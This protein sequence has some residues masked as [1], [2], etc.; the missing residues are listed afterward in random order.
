MS[1]LSVSMQDRMSFYNSSDLKIGLFGAKCSSGRAI[2]AAPDRWSGSWDDNLHMARI[3]DDAG[4]DF[5]LPI[6]RWRGYKGPTNYE[7]A[8]LETIN[9][10]TGLLAKTRRISV[11]ATMHVPLFHPIVA[12]KSMATADHTG[13]GRF[14]LNL[15][16][17][18]NTDEFA[19]LGVSMREHDTRYTYAQ[20]WLD[21]MTSIWSR[22]DEFDFD[23][24]FF[25]LKN[26]CGLP[27]PYGGS[28]PVVM[29]AGSSGVGTEFALRNCDAF[30]KGV[31]RMNFDGVTKGLRDFRVQAKA[32]GRTVDTYIIGVVCCR[33]T[34]A[35]AEEYIHH[36][37]VEQA[38]WETIDHMATMSNP[39]FP[40]FS[41]A[42]KQEI[43]DWYAQGYGFQIVGDPDQVT[44]ELM[45]LHQAGL[46]GIAISLF[47]Y[48]GALPFIAD[49]LLPRLV[50][51]GV[52]V[53]V[54]G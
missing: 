17:G 24:E 6:A 19:M 41:E 43:R 45:A 23:G 14:G 30:F 44:A 39:E 21:V 42:K 34:K 33:R 22:P 52:R 4:L 10:A 3:A 26:V 12:A 46:R 40:T 38:D 13:E 36:R 54:G 51:A 2:S 27:K 29:N 11:F 53:K 8:S 9:W 48:A 49:E 32:I 25:K 31:T 16:V 35:E 5:L 1:S 50:R 7:G 15:V 37:L 18:W 28:R 47:D 20:E